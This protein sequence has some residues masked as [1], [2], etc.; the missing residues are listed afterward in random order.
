M[1]DR[2]DA[3]QRARSA[4][5]FI[6]GEDLK[7]LGEGS[8]P[9]RRTGWTNY[10]DGVKTLASPLSLTGGSRTQITID[11][12]GSRTNSTYADGITH[13]AWDN[14]RL[15]GETVGE[16]FIVRLGFSVKTTEDMFSGITGLIASLATATL[17]A[18]VA[19]E[20]TV[21]IEFDFGIFAASTTVVAP[22]EQND[23][24]SVTE[25]FMVHTSSIVIDPGGALYL[26][27]KYDVDVWD[28]DLMVQRLYS[29]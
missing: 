6:T 12:L 23:T 19:R 7:G 1:G 2:T 16:S 22:R 10:H 5:K 17:K 18:A 20:N 24:A 15:K 26:T 14:N 25:L 8:E 13:A 28:F 9:A 29:P 4:G 3:I 27:S 11:G 21:K